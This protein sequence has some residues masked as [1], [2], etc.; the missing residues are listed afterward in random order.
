MKA[1]LD[2]LQ[3]TQQLLATL[4]GHLNDTF[5]QGKRVA[6]DLGSGF[7]VFSQTGQP[8]TLRQ[9][10]SGEQ[11]IV[12]LLAT[13]IASKAQPTLFLIDE[14]ELSLNVKWQ[15]ELV[16]AMLDCMRGARSQLILASHSHELITRYR[17][18]VVRLKG[19]AA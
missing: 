11:Q 15:R 18:S 19:N 4:V 9:L 16:A 14:P 2:A 6:Y 8:L 7:S 5:L 13:V 17:S 10:S 1:R 12:L 3:P